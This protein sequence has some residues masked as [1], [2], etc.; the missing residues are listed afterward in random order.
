MHLIEVFVS[1]T[2]LRV[3]GLYLGLVAPVLFVS[4]YDAE[5]YF[6]VLFLGF[7]SLFLILFICF[8]LIELTG[9]QRVFSFQRYGHAALVATWFLSSLVGM[10]VFLFYGLSISWVDALFASVSG[11]TTTGAEV[12]ED[13]SVFPRSLLFFRMWLQ[14]IGGMGIILMAIIAL[15]ASSGQSKQID[16]PG[17]VVSYSQKK[18]KL[19]DIGHYLWFIYS[20]ATIVCM[21]CMKSLGLTW[22]ESVCESMSIISTGGFT[23]YNAGLAYYQSEGVKI[24]AMLFVLFSSINFF[25]AL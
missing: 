8:L 11:L 9:F 19:S 15:G 13:L 24:I 4:W 25:A 12:F 2:L 6:H 21:L 1:N 20:A 16:L 22:F 23:L 14:F 18:P 10:F 5:V 17:P 3:I 7:L